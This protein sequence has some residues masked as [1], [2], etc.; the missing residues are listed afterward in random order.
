MRIAE[1][2]GADGAV[3]D[4]TFEDCEIVGPVALVGVGVDNRIIDCEYPGTPDYLGQ[5]PVGSGP[6]VFVID[7]TLRRC[8]F[9]PDVDTTELQPVS[10]SSQ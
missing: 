2:A 7:C 5:V 1:L 3:R 6:V 8:R 9:A 4:R 10:P